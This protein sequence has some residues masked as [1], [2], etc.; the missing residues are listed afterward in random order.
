MKDLQ[1]TKEFKFEFKTKIKQKINKR[2]KRLTWP[3]SR[4]VA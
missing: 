1:N 2:E 3:C 4:G